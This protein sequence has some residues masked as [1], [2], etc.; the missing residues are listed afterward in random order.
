M[1][2]SNNQQIQNL[3]RTQFIYYVLLKYPS[4]SLN[5][6]FPNELIALKRGK[7]GNTIYAANETGVNVNV[8][9]RLVRAAAD[10]VFLSGLLA[11][12]QA[13]LSSFVLL[14]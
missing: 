5:P 6:D 8:T 1:K 9:L 4:T 2:K 7:N 14:Y 12:Q 11:S 10:D 3:L 13:D